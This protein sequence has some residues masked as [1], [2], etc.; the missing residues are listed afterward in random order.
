M[1]QENNDLWPESMN[2]YESVRNNLRFNE[3]IVSFSGTANV[4]GAA[5]FAQHVYDYVDVNIGYTFA[6]V[7]V[8]EQ[9]KMVVDAELLHDVTEQM[10]GGAEPFSSIRGE[11]RGLVAEALANVTEG[12]TEVTTAIQTQTKSAA[13][14]IEKTTK[15]GVLAATDRLQRRGKPRK[16]RR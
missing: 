9:G 7:L 12:A 16:R 10:G 14:A 1:I 5:V 15:A 6:N 13:E 3:I 11:N 8:L 2:D 4:S